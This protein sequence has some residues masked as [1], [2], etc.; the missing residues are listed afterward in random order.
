MTFHAYID[1]SGTR[2]EHQVMT[3]SLVLLEGRRTAERIHTRV[4]KE[5]YPHLAETPK[6]LA[7]KKLHFTDMS[8]EDRIVVASQLAGDNVSAVINSHF[9]VVEDEPYEV[10]FA[11]YTHMVKLLLYKGLEF[12]DGELILTIAQQGGWETYRT[13]FLG[14]VRKVVD[15]YI[16]RSGTF[17][18]VD[19]ELRS[20]QTSQGLQ[21]ADF[22]AGAV[23]K[24]YLDGL[25][26]G[27]N[28]DQSGPYERVKH[29]ISL[30]DYIGLE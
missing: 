26:H 24:M 3:V 29:Q 19:M 1:E 11:R 2:I 23:R 13:A 16:K 18:T 22:Y 9:H 27:L 12:S 7:Q 30:E 15:L 6:L 17:R 4:L 21:L 28:P 20:A 8:D 14:D 5:L 10:F 25:N